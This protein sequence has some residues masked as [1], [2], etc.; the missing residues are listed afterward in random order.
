MAKKL[1]KTSKPMKAKF[2]AIIKGKTVL[3]RHSIALPSV[4][5][6]KEREVATFEKRG[7]DIIFGGYVFKKTRDNGPKGFLFANK[8]V[9]VY[10]F[11]TFARA[12]KWANELGYNGEDVKIIKLEPP[13][14]F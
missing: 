14:L 13:I 4:E 3:K 8:D 1:S 2:L 12:K 6:H 5:V 11:S 9:E 10:E 7:D